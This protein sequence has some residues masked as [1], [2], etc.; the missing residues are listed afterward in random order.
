MGLMIHALEG[1]REAIEAMIE[2]F[3]VSLTKNFPTEE[4][5][6]KIQLAYDMLAKYHMGLW[7]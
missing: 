1:F 5:S 2:G 3:K 6:N 7:R 4:E